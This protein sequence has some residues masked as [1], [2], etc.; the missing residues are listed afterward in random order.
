MDA[1]DI[2]REAIMALVKEGIKS[3][4]NFLTTKLARRRG[5]SEQAEIVEEQSEE[6][7]EPASLAQ[8]VSEDARISWQRPATLFWLG[9]DL[10][11]I[12]DQMYRGS[13]PRRVLQGVD[14]ALAYCRDLGFRQESFP[15]QNLELAKAHLELLPDIVLDGDTLTMVQQQYRSIEALVKQVKFFIQ[16]IAESQET[17]F[18]KRRAVSS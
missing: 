17:D 5:D 6:A 7:V 1:N 15:I 9:N 12:Q 4:F 11:W 14:N 16:G 2:Y 3:G 10:M 8:P 18:V 13:S